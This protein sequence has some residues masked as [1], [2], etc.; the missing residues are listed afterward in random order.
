V[1]EPEASE[2]IARFL[3]A[4]VR[5]NG[6]LHHV[7][8]AG[9]VHVNGFLEDYGALGGACLALYEATLESRWLSESVDIADQ[10]LSRFWSPEEAIFHDAAEDAEPLLVRPRDILDNATPSGNSLAVQL[11]VRLAA[12]V[13]SDRYRAVAD[14][15]LA[16]ERGVMERYPSALGGLL[17]AALLRTTPRLEVTLVDPMRAM[18]RRAHRHPH[19]NRIVTG[20]DPDD[21]V[22]AAL[23]SMRNRLAHRGRA[24]VCSG[25]ACLEPASTPEALDAA[26]AKV[27]TAPAATG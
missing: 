25:G 27:G 15:V 13:D 16:R 6:K 9:R 23:P 2:E 24:F 14:A 10:M 11:L 8:T 4:T 26:I 3:L 1:P 5:R 17:T 21:P 20:G 18:L 7:F 22:I 12:V 19:P